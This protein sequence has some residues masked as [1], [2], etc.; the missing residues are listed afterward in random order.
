MIIVMKS[1]AD[2]QELDNV[3]KWMESAG[4]KAHVSK[5]V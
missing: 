5:G 3:I 4:Y 1:K 2:Q